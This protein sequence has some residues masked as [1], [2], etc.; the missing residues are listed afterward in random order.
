MDVFCDSLKFGSTAA[1]PLDCRAGQNKG[2]YHKKELFLIATA[3]VVCMGQHCTKIVARYFSIEK[4]RGNLP[5]VAQTDQ[6][7][8]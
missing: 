1:I 6:L 7:I 5:P 4:S 3:L 2:R 8:I